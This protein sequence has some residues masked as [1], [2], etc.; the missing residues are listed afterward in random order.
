MKVI[1]CG[2][3]ALCCAG[4]GQ[5]ALA[6]DMVYAK[7]DATLLTE[8]NIGKPYWSLHAQCAG[9]YGAASGFETA[10]G[11]ADP[12]EKYKLIAV[13]MFN[14]AVARLQA[15]RGLDRPAA[16]ALATPELDYGRASAARMLADD[17]TGSDSGWNMLRSACQDISQAYHRHTP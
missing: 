7:G 15:D 11:H 6:L 1:A 2:L 10:S 4:I 16:I 5:S 8:S 14:D 13:G 9:V 17:G 12:A 3:A